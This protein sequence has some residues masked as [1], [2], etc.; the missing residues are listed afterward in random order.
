[1]LLATRM[2]ARIVAE[3]MTDRV[4]TEIGTT[5]V[6]R[7]GIV[8]ATETGTESEILDDDHGA[9]DEEEKTTA[10]GTTRDAMTETTDV[11]ID[12]TGIETE[13]ET[14]TADE[15]IAGTTGETKDAR[16]LV[17]ETTAA[18]NTMRTEIVSDGIVIAKIETDMTRVI[19]ET[20]T[21]TAASVGARRT[22]CS[23]CCSIYVLA[24]TVNICVEHSIDHT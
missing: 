6:R 10:T 22:W 17:T 7:I 21:D 12:E 18:G 3:R 1:M 4:G 24:R 2:T 11:T 8:S 13:T 5:T 19:E 20:E 14:E 15:K 9:H 16:A 23:R